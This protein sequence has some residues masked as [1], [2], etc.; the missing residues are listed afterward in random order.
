MSMT[1]TDTVSTQTRQILPE[2]CPDFAAGA[3]IL[4]TGGGGDPHIGMLMAQAALDKHGPADLVKLE[5]VP[6]DAV[7]IPVA[8]MGAPTVLVEKPA[9]AGQFV[10]S[11]RAIA[12]YL[13]VEPTHIA[14]ME[15]GGVNSMIPM[16]AAAE[17]G[18]PLIDADGMGRAFPELQM[19]LATLSG[20]QA[21]PMSISDEKGNSIV[22]ETVSNKWAERLA[23]VATVEM[24]CSTIVSLYAMTGEQVKSAFVPGT[25]S[26]C[27]EL[28][29]CISYSRHHA[30]SA[31]DA[32]IARLGAVQIAEGKISDVERRTTSGFARGR[33]ELR[34]ADGPV[35]IEFQNENLLVRRGDEV[36]A[37]TPDLI[38]GLDTD[39]GEAVT[40][41]QLRF[42][43]RISLIVAPA[44]E[45]W[46]SEG[47]LELAG[48]RYFGY[49]TDPVRPIEFTQS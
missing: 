43:T 11:I 40:T 4:G 2:D 27:R 41:E 29:E 33:A 25:L 23:R 30:G 10:E 15:A 22:L 49:D 26:L 34:T 6:D 47:G 35:E 13:G 14:C 36:V 7:V 45:R 48:P 19:V 9:S 3:A 28:G 18:L 38:I 44:D 12:K 1:E 32:V 39:T 42:G 21:A 24:G 31:K 16:A 37:T 17:L 46:H 5:D 20:V 8:M